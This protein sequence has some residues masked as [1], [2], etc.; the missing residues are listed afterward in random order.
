MRPKGSPQELEHIRMK[1]IAALQAG[2]AQKDVALAFGVTPV[3]IC[4]WNRKFRKNPKSLLA[5][6]IP[7]RTPRLSDKEMEKLGKLLLKGATAFGWP[8]DLWTCP[9]V[10][11]VILQEFGISFH[12]D[13]VFRLLT[14]KLNWTFQKPE[15]QARERDPEEVK[16]WLKVELPKIKKKPGEKKLR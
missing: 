8:N 4:V 11:E 5:Q 3:T 2:M 13:H 14:K 12:P 10:A 7:G 15:K 9:R 6:K 1:A 16:R